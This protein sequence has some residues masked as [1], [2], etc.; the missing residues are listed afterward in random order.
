MDQPYIGV[1]F[2]FCANFA[3]NG[4][5]LC[6]G[7]VIAI[8]QNTTLFNL[9]GTTYGGDGV[10]TFNLPD[11]RGRVPIHQGQGPGTSNYV[12][13]QQAGVENVTLTTNQIAAHSHSMNADN[14]ASTIPT[15]V[16]NAFLS[17]PFSGTGVNP[18]PVKIYSTNAPDTT[19]SP[20]SIGNA[21]GSQPLPI[22]QPFLAVNYILAQFGVFPSRN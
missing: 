5:A 14:N 20:A 6:D 18:P 2:P 13:G 16:T 22:I 7:R 4:W 15:P 9:I 8:D 21:G 3:P 12:I 11:L 10:Q 1:I 17:T 19:L